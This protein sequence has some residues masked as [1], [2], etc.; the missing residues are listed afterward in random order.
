MLDLTMDLDPEV[1]EEPDADPA[2]SGPPQLEIIDCEQNTE[3]WLLARLGIPTASEFHRI[4]SAGRADR[5]SETRRRYLYKLVAE[6][7]T[8]VPGDNGHSRHMD[9][10]HDDEEPAAHDY[11]FR[12]DCQVDTIGFMRHGNVGFSP[13]R[14][15]VNQPGYVEIK[16][17]L[18]DLQL[19]LLDDGEVPPE[20]WAQIQGGL[21]ISGYEWCD[22]VAYSAGLPLF[23]KRVVPDAEYIEYLAGHVAQF[24]Q[25]LDDAEARFRQQ[26]YGVAA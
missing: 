21:W 8:G 1:D 22:F 10:G 20:H 11:A 17:R 12:R 19:Q 13:D 15:V 7:L 14:I 25:E 3:Q 24:C 23:V 2:S 16:S 6:R 4:L 26:Y 9:R 5:P 18:P